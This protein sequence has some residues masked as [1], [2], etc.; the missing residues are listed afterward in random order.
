MVNYLLKVLALIVF[1]FV[2]IFIYY[3]P[4]LGHVENFDGY[5]SYAVIMLVIYSIYKY[6]QIS[7]G[8]DKVKFSLVGILGFFLLHLFILSTLF[9]SYNGFSLGYGLTLFFKII[10]YSIIPIIIV[11]LNVS[12]G[13]K[14]INLAG[15]DRDKYSFHIEEDK[16]GIYTFLFSL[17]L[18]FF[19][20]LTLLTVLGIFGFY[21]LFTVS[22][23]IILFGIFSFRELKEVWRGFLDYRITYTN[24]DLKSDSLIK[25]IALKLLST[26][27]LFIVATLIISINLISIVRPM[28]I[29]WDDLG[30]YM[31]YPRQMAYAG[32]IFGLGGMYAWQVFTGIG[33][34][35]GEPNQAFF[36]NNLGGILSFILIILVLSDLIK[37]ERKTLINI[38]LLLATLFISLPM[39]IFQQAKDMKLDAGL[40][41]ISLIALY[42][43]YKTF[44]TELF[45]KKQSIISKLKEKIGIEDKEKSTILL[46]ILFLIGILA[47]LAFTI[48]FTS[49][50]L[51]SAIIGALF[52]IKTGGFGFIGYLG[53]FFAVFTKFGLW[54]YMNVVYP[55]DNT[56]L[57][58]SFSIISF[59]IGAVFLSIGVKRNTIGEFKKLLIRL[60][61]FL[62]GVF[63]AMSPWIAKNIY[64][65]GGDISISKILN[66]SAERFVVD[67]E[68]IYTPEEKKEIDNNY[69]F[70]KMSD[71]GQ[72]TNE[73]F[74]RYFGYEEGINNYVKLPWNLTLQLNQGGEFTNIGFLFL[75]LLP[76]IL[77]FLPFRKEYYSL[78]VVTFLVLEI[79]LFLIPVT[80]EYLTG[81][82]SS[83]TLPFGYLVLLGIF[84]AIT[85]Y[86]LFLLK[87]SKLMTLFRINLVFTSFY[88]FLWAISAFGVVWY[89]IM[90]YFGFLIMIGI[91]LHYMTGYNDEKDTKEL[92]AKFFGA[93]IILIIFGVWF[94]ASVVPHAFNNL[95]NA[96]YP[97]Y[98][99]SQYTKEELVFGYHH[100]YL[101]MLFTLNIAKDKREEFIL[102]KLNDD[103]L[104]NIIQNYTG[105]IYAVSEILKIIEA[106]SF[107]KIFSKD[108]L[109]KFDQN[110][111][112]L[113]KQK[114]RESKLAIY[115]G[116]LKP[117]LEYKNSEGVYRIGTFLRYFIVDNN[118][119]LYEDALIVSFDKYINS[120]NVDKTVD[121]M[122][123]IGLS[124][125]LVDLNAAT[126][127]QDPRHD[128]TRRYENLLKTFTSERLTLVETDSI[129]LKYALEKYNLSD[130]TDEDLKEYMILAGVNF[131][132]YTEDGE[133]IGRQNKQIYCYQSIINTINSGEVLKNKYSY[134][135]EIKD[136]LI[137][138]KDELDT[139]EKQ[140]YEV[141]KFAPHGARVLFEIR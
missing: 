33:Y 128:L 125:L 63:V 32:Q 81:L 113:L 86:L 14:L 101:K 18:G 1:S 111:L 133:T 82:M 137:S 46:K 91:S 15:I 139:E 74:G 118:K 112:N 77:I 69:S 4:S 50:L 55:V 49:L 59:I 119:R 98:K 35:I 92:N 116:I 65:S 19:S 47:G 6:Y 105:D 76:A 58:N 85:S 56:V 8:G 80:K 135:N 39:I 70:G 109:A 124:Y 7:F 126:I 66:G 140:V 72:T 61:V 129:C 123:K 26:E 78:A 136:T 131:E 3:M 106:G 73:D 52:Y 96:Q 54:K 120:E 38:P 68:K 117:S 48:K 5:M 88:V 62:L 25:N 57:I 95:K 9:F 141:S 12:F 90:M 130:K 99:S 30:V 100:D 138:K 79:L 67:Y 43:L 17:G 28:P 37:S 29:G 34:M 87:H 134:L 71:V 20:F 121:K 41:F 16:N 107:E 75:A 102:S 51:I 24:H 114:A 64:E 93:G 115:N 127:D 36:L 13:K 45:E 21:N 60:G 40:F 94:L 104:K 27:F 83:I 53:V 84:I 97:Y 22:A 122:K 23:L 108:V 10:G 42:V 11:F 31:N 103:N 110:K 132:S 2:V 89:G 44:F